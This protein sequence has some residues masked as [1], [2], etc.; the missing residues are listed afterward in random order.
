M[1]KHPKR[2]RRFNLRR[3]RATP[4]QAL[5][6]LA[7]DTVSTVAVTAASANRYRAMILKVTWSISNLTA[8][9]GPITVGYSHSDYSV[10]EVK[11]C[12]E[13]IQAVDPGDKISMERANRLVR[14]VGSLGP[15]A[16]SQLNNG[17]PIST[18]LN[19]DIGIGD[20]VD[21]FT[22]NESTAALTTGAFIN[23]I[24]DMFIK[25]GV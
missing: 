15:T 16:N 11:E 24:G 8:G 25:D 17:M 4:E 20:N 9:E 10:T 13:A 7:S 14:V 1:A 6:T 21:I 2:R 3:V 19:W 5:G 23:W 18:K 12:L 22:Y